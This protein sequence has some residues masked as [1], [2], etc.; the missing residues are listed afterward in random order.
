MDDARAVG[1]IET[2]EDLSDDVHR[3]RRREAAFAVDHAGE[4]LSFEALHHVERDVRALV[5]EEL[6]GDQVRVSEARCHLGLTTEPLEVG[7]VTGE[8]RA[9]DLDGHRPARRDVRSLVDAAHAAAPEELAEDV[10]AGEGP[11]GHGS[12]KA[13]RGPSKV[14]SRG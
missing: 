6:D 7:G 2:R 12:R 3:A 11:S 13:H 5:V 8:L 10:A 14:S 4:R 1:G 9:Q